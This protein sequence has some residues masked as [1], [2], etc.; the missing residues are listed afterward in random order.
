MR[1]KTKWIFVVF[2]NI[3]T[4]AFCQAGVMFESVVW[5]HTAFEAP[6]FIL[7]VVTP[8]RNPSRL[9][10]CAS[11]GIKKEEILLIWFLITKCDV[12]LVLVTKFLL[13]KQKK[14][15]A[16]IGTRWWVGGEATDYLL[17]FSSNTEAYNIFSQDFLF[18]CYFFLVY[19]L[20]TQHYASALFTPLVN[21]I[22]SSSSSYCFPQISFFFVCTHR[23]FIKFNK[24]YSFVLFYCL[25]YQLF[26]FCGELIVA[27]EFHCPSK[28]VNDMS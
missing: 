27:C 17:S 18:L 9:M 28:W 22:T 2:E 10:H 3:R 4:L 1:N 15:I 13:P 20:N 25:S 14:P 11:W 24:K 16:A 6:L 23:V 7:S 8:F 26:S 5:K 12:L 21:N 19:W